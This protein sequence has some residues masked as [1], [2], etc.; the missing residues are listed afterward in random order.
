[1]KRQS[2][3]RLK[4]GHAEAIVTQLTGKLVPLTFQIFFPLS[5]QLFCN[6]PFCLSSLQ[7]DQ[8][9]Q[10]F[11][12][13]RNTL[14]T[15][16][17]YLHSPPPLRSF[18]LDQITLSVLWYPCPP[19]SSF[20]IHH[21]WSHSQGITPQ[22]LP[23]RY[24]NTISSKFKY[25]SVQWGLAERW[26]I[27]SGWWRWKRT[28]W[29]IFFLLCHSSSSS[30][31]S[32]LPSFWVNWIVMRRSIAISPIEMQ[33]D[34]LLSQAGCD[35]MQRWCLPVFKKKINHWSIPFLPLSSP[36]HTALSRSPLSSLFLL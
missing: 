24:T 15:L 13:C 12:S 25:T 23:E 14:S 33:W 22:R 10:V 2:Y 18:L 30:T 7:T 32:P 17:C 27:Y 35:R 20:P 4:S 21:V 5:L 6:P 16:P 36:S 28:A 26:Q 8:W 9:I 31:S 29:L 3:Y 1:M 34:T 11:S 19:F